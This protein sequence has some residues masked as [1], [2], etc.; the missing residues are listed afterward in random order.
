MRFVTTCTNRH[1]SEDRTGVRDR[2]SAGGIAT[3]IDG[4]G[5]DDQEEHGQQLSHG[6]DMDKQ[7]LSLLLQRSRKDSTQEQQQQQQ[8]RQWSIDSAIGSN[9]KHLIT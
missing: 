8:E 9:G 7:L 6:S 3:L 5:E 1:D 4:S 2:L